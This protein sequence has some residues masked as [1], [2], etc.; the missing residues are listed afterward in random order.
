VRPLYAPDEA[1]S[2]RRQISRGFVTLDHAGDGVT[3]MTSVTGGKLTT[4]RRMAE[5]T[6]DLVCDRLDVDVACR[7]ADH[8]LPGADDPSTLDEYVDTYDA[9][10]P[11]DEPVVGAE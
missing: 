4:Y 8:A 6:A 1:G 2:D 9:R 3:N 7:T 11:T 10:S 5:A